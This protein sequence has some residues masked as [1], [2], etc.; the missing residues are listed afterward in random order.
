MLSN[1]SGCSPA[2]SSNS[3]EARSSEENKKTYSPREGENIEIA[4]VAAVSGD[5]TKRKLKSRHIQLIG[6]VFSFLLS[7]ST[8]HR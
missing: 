8:R 2:G 5:R 4:S 1:G 7:E 6:L 3:P